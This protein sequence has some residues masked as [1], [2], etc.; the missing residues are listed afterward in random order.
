MEY[1]GIRIL[2]KSRFYYFA[3]YCGLLGAALLVYRWHKTA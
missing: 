2:Q 3:I 1:L